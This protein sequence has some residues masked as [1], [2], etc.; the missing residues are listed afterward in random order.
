MSA[1]HTV[2]RLE[3]VMTSLSFVHR[4]HLRTNASQNNV[5]VKQRSST[6]LHVAAEL[7]IPFSCAPE[8][9]ERISVRVLIGQNL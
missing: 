7:A 9:R 4:V 5:L 8:Q 1:R 3:L 6:R 2:P